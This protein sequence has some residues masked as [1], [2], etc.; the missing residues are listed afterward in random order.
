MNVIT[1]PRAM[2]LKDDLVVVPRKEYESLLVFR[3]KTQAVDNAIDDG[4]QEYK[5]GKYKGP[6]TLSEARDFL[7]SR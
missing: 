4:L 6:F 7:K 1:I 3:C 2:S 5:K